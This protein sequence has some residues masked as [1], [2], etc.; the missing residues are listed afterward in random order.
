VTGGQPGRDELLIVHARAIQPHEFS[1]T[2]QTDLE[3]ITFFGPDI[4]PDI[5]MIPQIRA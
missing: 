3:I 2:G 4:N 5:P 1:N